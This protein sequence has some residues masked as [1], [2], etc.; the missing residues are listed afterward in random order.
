MKVNN[1]TLKVISKAYKFEG[2]ICKLP[3][4]RLARQLAGLPTDEKRQN[5]K[6]FQLWKTNLN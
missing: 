2:V 5:L 4:V 1:T 6:T 3:I